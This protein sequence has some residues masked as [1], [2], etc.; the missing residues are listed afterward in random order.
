MSKGHDKTVAKLSI[1]G[2]SQMGN[3]GRAEVAEWLRRQAN[4]LVKDGHNYSERFTGRY[5]V[6]GKEEV[7]E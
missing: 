1:F 5:I 7:G 4:S 6:P 2:A 3:E